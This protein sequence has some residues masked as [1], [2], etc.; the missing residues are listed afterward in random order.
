MKQQIEILINQ[1]QE[2]AEAHKR[3]AELYRQNKLCKDMFRQ[4]NALYNQCLRIKNQLAK[5]IKS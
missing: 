1:L 5:I 4:Q 2:E 3:Y